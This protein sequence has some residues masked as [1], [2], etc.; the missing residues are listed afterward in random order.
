MLCPPHPTAPLVQD[1]MD[2]H[3]DPRSFVLHL[4][5]IPPVI[6]AVLLFPVYTF[7]LSLPV[8]LL[9]VS[10]FIG[11]YLVQFLGHAFDG[12]EPGEWVALKRFAARASTLGIGGPKSRRRVA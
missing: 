10:L 1:W 6:V 5:G 12:T 8:F 9:S 11:G 7:L 2:R 3:R 4:I